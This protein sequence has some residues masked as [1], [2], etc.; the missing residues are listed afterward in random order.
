MEY[1][2]LN[3]STEEINKLLDAIPVA[4]TGG[5]GTV[6]QEIQPNRFYNFGECSSLTVTLAEGMKGIYNEY[7]L[8]FTSGAVATTLNL[9]ESIRWAEIPVIESNKT[10]QIS[11]LNN[12]AVIGGWSNE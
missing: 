9:P 7:M 10:Y 1:G 11:I 12:L 6:T 8:Q 4:I 3:K 2:D 5:S